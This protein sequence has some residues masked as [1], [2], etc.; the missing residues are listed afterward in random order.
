[1]KPYYKVYKFKCNKC[2]DKIQALSVSDI[3]NNGCPGC[4]NKSI[5]VMGY[6]R[7]EIN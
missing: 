3:F 1:M 5:T 4:K 2:K 6:G 7:E